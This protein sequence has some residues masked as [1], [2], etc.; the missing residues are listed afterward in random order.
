MGTIYRDYGSMNFNQAPNNETLVNHRRQVYQATHRGDGT[1]L[2]FMNRSFISF[3]YGGKPIEDF[4]LIATIVNNRI[5]KDAYASFDDITTTY[6]NL[7]GQFYW[8]THYRTNSLT[9]V[10]S[11][12][13]IDQK[14]LEEFRYWFHAGEAKE[15]ILSEH[16]NRAI[17]A[18]VA[19]P[20]EL[21][22]LPFE[23]ATTVI[24]S[25][26][27]YPTKTT[28]YKGDITLVLITEEPH[29]YAIQNL[30]GVEDEVNHR[31]IDQWL[32]TT[33][34]PP[35]LIDIFASADALKILQ[36]D[37]VPLGSMIS[38]NM[39][40]GN[41]AFANVENNDDS[42][43]WSVPEAEIVWDEGNP[44]G[45]G[46]RIYGTITEETYIQNS[47]FVVAT[48][49]LQ[50]L[51]I[52]DGTRL[53]FDKRMIASTTDGDFLVSENG[54]DLKMEDDTNLNI[55]GELAYKTD[56][57]DYWPG[58]YNGIIAGAI[59]DISGKGITSLAAE[60]SGH[61]FYSG[62]APSPTIIEFDITPT[63]NSDGYFNAINNISIGNGTNNYNT[64]TIES[65]NKQELK[66]TTP[67]L[68]TSYN[69]AL[70]I[71]YAGVQSG[72]HPLLIYQEIVN[73]VRHKAVR[74]WVAALLQVGEG[75]SLTKGQIA[76]KMVEFFQNDENIYENMH[77]LFN[78][79]TGEAIGHFHYRISTSPGNETS[80]YVEITENVGD[81]LKSNNVFIMDRNYADE[82]GHIV[83]WASTSDATKSYSHRIYHDLPVPLQH[84]QIYY[85]N[86]YL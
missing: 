36:E 57:H 15:L 1:R 69:K 56:Y 12:D 38:N 50:P 83:K 25:G 47:R 55:N 9:F 39:L 3:T 61:F 4:D 72:T 18:R 60:Q 8:N 33:L 42:K 6:D 51:T 67:N 63:F 76:T 79:K 82:D 64:I 16:P 5:N 23:Q 29:W 53:S 74:S 11:T 17:M 24:I 80:R 41:G 86:M 54:N 37:G 58:Q 19:Q 32:D 77:F 66:I 45:V 26:N 48:D 20:P 31:Y 22:L 13:G 35:Q 84:L 65:I 59:V 43:I 81:M 78:S 52:E 27:E 40:L 71:L 34:N 68:I 62:T 21:S 14:T 7:D 70:D 49:N 46:A 2:P 30:L 73:N 10:L 28:L 75:V 85:R 44:S